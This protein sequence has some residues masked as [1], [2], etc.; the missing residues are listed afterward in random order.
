MSS[1]ADRLKQARERAGF[2]TAKEACRALGWAYEAYKKHEADANGMKPEVVERYAEGF[3]V[4]AQ[5]IMFGG[6]APAPVNRERVPRF[7]LLPLWTVK[8]ASSM[9]ASIKLS[10]AARQTA[11]DFGP[12]IGPHAF[13]VELDDASMTADPPVGADSFNP[14]D[15][16]TICPDKPIKPGDFVL[17]HDTVEELTTFRRYRGRPGHDHPFELVPLNSAFSTQVVHSTAQGE[18]VGRLIRHIRVYR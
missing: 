8:E 9:G 14:G 17:F 15:L 5:W 18:I 10:K 13:C 1:P 16:V 7:R 11:V 12:D 2:A 4:T 6:T 3:G